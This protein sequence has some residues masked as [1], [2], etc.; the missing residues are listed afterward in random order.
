MVLNTPVAAQSSTGAYLNVKDYGAVG[1]GTTDDTVAI[2]NALNAASVAGG[3]IVLFPTGNYLLSSTIQIITPV[4]LLG[5][6]EQSTILTT[7]QATG[8]VISVIV[9]G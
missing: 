7:N 8:D 2:R 6:G 3:G 5:S 1:N 4:I 9:S